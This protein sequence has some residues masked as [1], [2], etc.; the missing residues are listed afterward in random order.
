MV[1]F[2]ATCVASKNT[3][4]LAGVAKYEAIARSDSPHASH[5]LT[6][7]LREAL[8]IHIH[9]SSHLIR[10]HLSQY[11][12]RSQRRAILRGSVPEYLAALRRYIRIGESALVPLSIGG[13]D[14]RLSKLAR[15]RFATRERCG[16]CAHGVYKRLINRFVHAC[17]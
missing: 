14:F 8:N 5:H 15:N 10:Q 1:L 7:L 2:S 3:T 16:I 6:R 13:A 12:P 9:P 11:Y 17:K 4:A